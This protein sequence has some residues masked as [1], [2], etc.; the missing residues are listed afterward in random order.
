MSPFESQIGKNVPRIEGREK[1]TGLAAYTDDLFRPGML[2]G[3]LLASPYPH[4]R[5]VSYDVSAALA[6]P[7]VHCVLTG[8]DFDPRNRMGAF[9][10][11]E[12]PI[13][14]GRVRY[15]GEPVAAVAAEDLETARRAARLIEV[16]YEELPAVLTPEEAMAP[17]APVLHEELGD[18]FKTIED[19][20]DGNMMSF[21]EI[22]EGDVEQGWRD[23]EIIVEDEFETQAQYH[24][25]IETCS[26]LADIDAN[27]RVSVYSPNQSVFRVQANVCQSL[28]IP[29]TALRC[30][31]PRIGAGYGGRM[32]PHVQPITVALARAARKSVKLTLTR[33]EDFEQVR[34]RHPYKLRV[35]TGAKRDG[36]FVAREVETVLDCG[37]Y[38]DDSPGVLAYSTLMARGPYRIPHSRCLGRAV[39]TNKLRSGAFRGF[40]QPQV[41]FANESS[42]DRLADEL[43]MDRVEI[44]LKNAMTEGDRWFGG[45]TVG[46]NGVIECLEK[47]R[48]AS[49]WEG[50][51]K[52]PT[53][54]GK[55]KGMGV[56]LSSHVSAVLSTGA[57]VRM[58]GDGTFVLNTG[59]AEVGQG[60][61]TVLSQICAEGFKVPV[62]NVVHA[63][64]DTDGSPYTWATAA[65]RVTHLTGR[66]V[67]GAVGQALVQIME[68]AAELLEC[69]AQD[70]ELRD[71]GVVALKGANKEVPFAAI[72]AQ[73]HN[74]S[75]GAIIGA[76]S[77]AY[78]GPELDPKR[79]SATGFPFAEI[80]GF[81]F[82][83]TISEVEVDEV[84]GKTEVTRCWTAIDLGK[85]INPAMVEGQ[86]HGGYAQAM[87][88]ALAEE[89]IW[90]AGRLANPS[91]M[92]YKAPGALDVPYDL[93]TIIVEH[94]EP[95]GPFG[96]KGAGEVG[97]IGAPASISGAVAEALDKQ[98]HRLPLTPERVLA[99]LLDENQEKG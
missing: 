26:A 35:K 79:A 72:S 9:I 65:S 23:S 82:A 98:I 30:L 68:R 8:A 78:D 15:T 3:A 41:T 74:I 55:R 53:T 80:G 21:T 77:L 12:T 71:G 56:A 81:S 89:M 50:R 60:A 62:G 69:D 49:G 19:N 84:T 20:F 67:L 63:T 52:L 45:L 66:A 54:P 33:A 27:G 37:A 39:Y 47:A 34:C 59:A 43:G 22:S 38:A 16:E 91:L 14:V 51:G 28:G 13:A 64:P 4:A 96:A 87:G 61:E 32:E 75:G 88:M 17:G 11:D 70:C 90:D 76:Y 73:A 31:S 85:A 46:S 7:G 99:A 93:N 40:G 95:M 42:I 2:H 44:R 18:Y 86:I 25:A 6:L 83:A 57:I 97:M 36:T 10:R 92:D 48:T 94:P 24:L 1:V 29:M 5:L 58:L